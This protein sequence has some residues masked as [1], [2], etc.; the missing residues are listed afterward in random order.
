MHSHRH[1]LGSDSNP[2][3]VLTQDFEEEYK[4][5]SSE[6]EDINGMQRHSFSCLDNSLI[7][8]Q[9]ETRWHARWTTDTLC[10]RSS[11]LTRGSHKDSNDA[12]DGWTSTDDCAQRALQEEAGI[13]NTS[14]KVT[15]LIIP[16]YGFRA[17]ELPRRN[18]HNLSYDVT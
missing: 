6:D 9:M 12:K 15:D 7:S 1:W 18:I 8:K 11:N 16:E 2:S 17:S 3:N 13:A 14:T 10:V 5:N 4:T